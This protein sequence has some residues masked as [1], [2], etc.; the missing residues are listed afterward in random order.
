MGRLFKA[1]FLLPLLLLL[2]VAHSPVF[3]AKSYV[4][5]LGPQENGRRISPQDIADVQNSHYDLMG[6]HM[7]SNERAKQSIIYSYTRFINGFA[8]VMD[9]T[10]AEEIAKN[11][12]VMAVFPN[13]AR[14]LHTTRTWDF[15]GL[16]K[17]GTAIPG[18]TWERARF[19]EDTIIA[20]LDTGVWPESA[21]FNDEG[22]DPIPL[23]WKGICQQGFKDKI[24]CNRKLIGVRYFN[25]GYVAEG[26]TVTDD[27]ATPR[28][29]EGHGTHTLSTAGGAFVP[30][31]NYF[32]FANGTMKGGSPR[33][34]VAAYKVCWPAFSDE[35][36]CYDADILAA[37]ESAIA[38]GVDVISF[39]VGGSPSEFFNDAIAV[40][41]FHATLKGI[42]VV[43]SGGNE[44][45]KA[46]TVTNLA[47][48]IFTVAASTLDRDC[49]SYIA[50]GNRTHLKGSSMSTK[51]LPERKFYPLI[52]AGDAKA[53]DAM[54]SDALLCKP[55]SLD[56]S[57]VN[58]KILI[59]LRGV[60]ARLDK[61]ER[62]LEAGAVGMILVNDN[63]DENDV[64]H[65][66]HVLPA[67]HINY[68]DGQILFAYYNSTLSPMAF[69]TKAATVLG[70]K[71]APVMADFSSR[72]PNT[73]EP[74]ILKPDITAPG[75]DI[76]ASLSEAVDPS[77]ERAE[78]ATP[79]GFMSGTS[80]SCPHIAGIVGL[81]RTAYP[82]WSPAAIRSA[83]MT[84]A[85]TFDNNR[86]VIKD[87]HFEKATPFQFGAGHVHPSQ[88][89]DPGLVYDLGPYD[90]M[91]FLCARTQNI[92]QIRL[93][94]NDS[95]ACPTTFSI[96]NFNYP[97][98]TVPDLNNW[99]VITRR[100]KNVGPP[101]KYVARVKAPRGITVA[102]RPMELIFKQKGEEKEFEVLFRTKAWAKAE[103]YVFGSLVWSDGKHA[104]RSP[105][106]VKPRTYSVSIP[107]T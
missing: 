86:Q 90:Y 21:S 102:V 65:Y 37:F 85:V 10:Q 26:G 46:G 49:T 23:R 35:G 5:Y 8:A 28:D 84:T 54:D 92:S 104:V 6:S 7:E 80:M 51:G 34:R 1:R 77:N 15:L 63:P 69:M 27:T 58:G 106:V 93:F 73:I 57:K 61:G 70:T 99:A 83:I 95:Y 38:D 74:A 71:P 12:N 48:W 103:E 31:A 76:L 91:N 3:A 50:L 59:C 79:F 2:S 29:V 52:T 56:P 9:E 68:A 107:L 66:S 22:M 41:S 72:G 32:G 53:A 64:F 75:V 78:P 44:G 43:A 40:G 89:L 33:A 24:T 14:K 94:I 60:T 97:S 4:V 105:I 45:P 11:P 82:V 87:L 47:P 19:G 62:A 36:G 96:L 25:D 67:S 88:V 42:P 13:R 18:S 81:L 98:I 17:D 30:K 20:N 55:R 100:V 16:G 101:G 39:S